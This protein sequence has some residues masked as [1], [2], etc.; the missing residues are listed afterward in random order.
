M[1]NYDS[2]IKLGFPREGMAVQWLISRG[3]EG[4]GAN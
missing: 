4:G 3:R 1:S 2:E